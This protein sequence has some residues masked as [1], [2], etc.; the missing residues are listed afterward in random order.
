MGAKPV[1]TTSEIAAAVPYDLP[2]HHLFLYASHPMGTCRMGG[3][4][5][6]SVVDPNGK[7]WGWANL[8]VADASTFPTSLGVNPQVTT[9]AI[10]LMVG[11]SIADGNRQQA[12]A[13]VTAVGQLP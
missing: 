6:T 13:T 3:D 2:A 9:M 12:Q 5:A 8:R 7:V 10:G 11:E 1:R 4:P